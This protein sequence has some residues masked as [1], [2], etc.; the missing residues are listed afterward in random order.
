[1][2]DNYNIEYYFD[3]YR[4]GVATAEEK[5][6]IANW[7]QQLNILDNAIPDERIAAYAQRSAA[8]LRE[9]LAEKTE[10]ETGMPVIKKQPAP[11][12][13]WLYWAAASCI[14]VIAIKLFNQQEKKITPLASITIPADKT[15]LRLE[16]NVDVYID[17]VIDSSL[18][19]ENGGLV[20]IRGN[21]ILYEGDGK[22]S[23]TLISAKGKRYK[24]ALPDSTKIWLNASS[25][26]RF[27]QNARLAE[28]SGEAYF[29]VSHSELH[30][31]TVKPA[32]KNV[33]VRVLG[34]TF[35]VSTVNNVIQTTLVSG[36]VALEILGKSPGILQPSQKATYSLQD[37]K[38]Q[39]QTVNTDRETDWVY[40]RLVFKE[41]PVSEVLTR[42]SQFY[43]V[44]FDV[45]D[46]KIYENI[47]TGTFENKPLE[48]ILEYMKMTSGIN[49]TITNKKE[50]MTVQL[51]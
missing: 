26:L 11:A 3:R 29:E 44:K 19:L 6:L 34:T 37:D 5:Q 9:R 15:L 16:N 1:M 33:M 24:V 23:F 21:E 2:E 25:K 47:F 50:H 40:N 17:H 12:Y 49:Y 36:K 10:R 13:H 51:N 46:K 4:R 38:L 45:K 18:T 20:H 14:L 8:A 7:L 41:T 42:V 48:R 43:D 32:D 35:D 39:I 28:V 27:T 30:P 22:P 31:F